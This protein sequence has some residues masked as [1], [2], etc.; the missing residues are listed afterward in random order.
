MSVDCDFCG[1]SLSVIGALSK[2][3]KSAAGGHIKQDTRTLKI[4]TN[5]YKRFVAFCF[6]LPAIPSIVI[7]INVTDV[8]LIC[9]Q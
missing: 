8:I 5:F 9:K 2:V 3:D 7:S 4:L 1:R 6:L